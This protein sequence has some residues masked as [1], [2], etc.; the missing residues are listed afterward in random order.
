M[1]VSR[2]QKFSTEY[3][4][5]SGVTLK[6]SRLICLL[7]ALTV[8]A[9][10]EWPVR[11]GYE[12]I[13]YSLADPKPEAVQP[14][15][16]VPGLAFA[17]REYALTPVDDFSD[18]K[19][20]NKRRN[21]LADMLAIRPLDP[22]DWLLLAEIDFDAHAAPSNAVEAL[23]LSGLTGPNEGYLITQRGLFGVW[24]WEAL[25]PAVRQRAV[26]D[27]L[28]RRLTDK[29]L[30]WLRTTIADKPEKAREEIRL[31]LQA[32]GFGEANLARIGL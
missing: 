23:E 26:A 7:T 13:R 1:R 28:A 29:N 11:K 9:I 17:A 8:I 10:C 2:I 19:T 4:R 3:Q 20:I 12:L 5:L 14:W 15:I 24:Q 22:Y 6:R 27:L 21:E 30:D 18:D 32:R 16:N 31:A 25:T